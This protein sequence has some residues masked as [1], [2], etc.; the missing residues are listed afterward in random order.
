M[1]R[2]V[3]VYNS[4]VQEDSDII[5]FIWVDCWVSPRWER[6]SPWGISRVKKESKQVSDMMSTKLRGAISWKLTASKTTAAT[7]VRINMRHTV[8]RPA[9]RWYSAAVVSCCEAS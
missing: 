1:V 3:D 5:I 8:R 2:F 4:W 7:T 9:F 6:V